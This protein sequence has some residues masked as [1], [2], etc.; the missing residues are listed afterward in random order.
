MYLL[1]FGQLD[2]VAISLQTFSV[3]FFAFLYHFF[4]GRKFLFAPL[5]M[6]WYNDVN[7]MEV[8]NINKGTLEDIGDSAQQAV[9]DAKE[10]LEYYYI[11]QD[12]Q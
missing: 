2:L 12:F 3:F 5:Q 10:Q 8:D 9:E 4:E 11:H 7:R 6:K 1:N